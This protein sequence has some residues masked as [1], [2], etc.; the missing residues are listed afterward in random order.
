[1]YEFLKVT[2]CTSD[3]VALVKVVSA[4]RRADSVFESA[5]KAACDRKDAQ[6]RNADAG[7]LYEFAPIKPRRGQGF[8]S[9]KEGYRCLAHHQY[10][11]PDR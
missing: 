11:V 1:L 8:Y 7:D 4:I 5:A 10:S 9:L 6:S 3:L 2:F